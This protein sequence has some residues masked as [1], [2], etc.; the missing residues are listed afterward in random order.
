MASA[1]RKFVEDRNLLEE[2]GLPADQD[3][4]DP[5]LASPKPEPEE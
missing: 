2:Q 1:A 3:R 5:G 4:G